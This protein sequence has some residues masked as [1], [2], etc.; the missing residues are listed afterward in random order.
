MRWPWSTC[1]PSL[2]HLRSAPATGFFLSGLLLLLR[3]HT[4]PGAVRICQQILFAEAWGMAWQRQ[5]HP[6]RLVLNQWWVLWDLPCL[7]KIVVC[8]HQ[9][10]AFWVDFSVCVYCPS[11]CLLV[12]LPWLRSTRSQLSYQSMFRYTKTAG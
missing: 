9:Q 5:Q 8:H 12:F 6:H 4:P 7:V 11:S 10:E 3:N 1:S 2:T